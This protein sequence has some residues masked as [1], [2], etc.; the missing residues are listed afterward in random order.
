MKH[1]DIHWPAM[2]ASAFLGAIFSFAATVAFA[3]YWEK[4]TMARHEAARHPES[5]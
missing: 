5:N 3:V 4:R 1:N 2:F